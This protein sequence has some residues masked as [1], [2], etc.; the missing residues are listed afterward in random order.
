ML[1]IVVAGSQ[2]Q[3]HDVGVLI[4]DH[5]G[6]TKPLCLIEFAYCQVLLKYPAQK[7]HYFISM[8][9][10]HLTLLKCPYLSI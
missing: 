9:T 5:R 2:S 1:S 10:P 4:Q 7:C 3:V 8:A 6:A